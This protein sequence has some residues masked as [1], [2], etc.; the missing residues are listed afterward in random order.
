MLFS[1]QEITDCVPEPLQ[2]STITLINRLGESQSFQ[3]LLGQDG[4]FRGSLLRVISS[5]SFVADIMLRFEDHLPYLVETGR[6]YRTSTTDELHAIFEAPSEQV[7]TER[8]KLK[9]LRSVRHRELVRIAWRDISGWASLDETLQDLTDLASAAICNAV[10]WAIEDL[11]DRYG[12][13]IAA[14]G[15]IS[16]FIVLAMGKL[17]GGELNFS[18]DIDLVLLYSKNAETNGHRSVTSEQYFRSLSQCVINLLDKK[19]VDGFVYRVDVRLRPFGNSGPLTL[20]TAAL[21]SYLMQH[22]RSWERYAYLKARVVNDWDGTA[23]FYEDILR[24]FVYRRYVDYGVFSALREIKQQIEKESRSHPGNIKLGPGGIREIEFVVQSLQMVRGGT[25]EGLRERSLFAALLELRKQKCLTSEAATELEDSYRFLRKLEN[26]IQEIADQQTQELPKSE[27][28]R[29]RI[30]LAMDYPDWDT[31]MAELTVYRDAVER[32]FHDIILKGGE[33]PDEENSDTDFRAIWGEELSDSAALDHI[34]ANGF[35]DAE[36][37]LELI[38]QLHQSSVYQRMEETARQRVD[39]LIPKLIKAASENPMPSRALEG[40]LE[41][42]QAIG[43]RSAYLALLI[44]N[45]AALNHLVGL[46]AKS[47]PLA[48]QVAAFPV[49]LDELLDPQIFS[50]TASRE[51]ISSEIRSRLE[52]VKGDDPEDRL[53]AVRNFQQ[54]AVFRVAVADLSGAF[55]VRKV[56]DQLTD[57]A[58]LVLQQV[59]DIAWSDLCQQYGAPFC[60]D[61]GFRPA[62]IGIVAAGQFGGIELGYG[63]ELELIFLHNS[64]GTDQH[65]DG[66]RQLDNQAF[67]AR[68]AKRVVNILTMQTLSGPLYAVDTRI[69]RNGL[70]GLLVTSFS[71]FEQHQC[72][73]A[74]TCEHQA[75]L[76]SRVV[77]GNAGMREIFFDLRLRVLQSHVRHDTLDED[78]VAIY[79]K[80]HGESPN[81]DTQVF[82]ITND[83]GGLNDIRCLVQYLILKH[84]NTN[85]GLLQHTDGIRQIEA[86]DAAKILTPEETGS[87]SMIYNGYHENINRL[88]LAERP[89]LISSD[90]FLADEFS[91]FRKSITTVWNKYFSA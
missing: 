79:A 14:D 43:H 38:R 64:T 33:D 7:S 52:A 69:R 83:S 8:E 29:A 2:E 30:C 5:S 65:T 62:E 10:D 76:H 57:I 89:A 85:N 67:F 25:V 3:R 41:V 59:L 31:L 28:D 88:Y 66:T 24:P 49:L 36:K 56:N 1:S 61:N 18:S 37:S 68:L 22:G 15:S 16:D 13:P 78:M 34:R 82:D 19:S 50:H 17:G 39:R 55:S 72:E 70:P 44:E 12:Q 87:L 71:A 75:L 81:S 84:A 91:E 63:S 32:H 51:E 23:A 40:A 80:A 42:I 47:K 48:K 9:Q 54:A 74:E 46:A 58:E 73:E 21:E 4:K 11:S 53:E 35:R 26:S 27:I 60:D 86:L 77:A 45:P 20:S 6:L 90:D